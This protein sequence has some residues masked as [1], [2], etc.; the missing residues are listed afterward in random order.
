M[1]NKFQQGF[2]KRAQAYGICKFDAE[3]LL[4]EAGLGDWL[5][6]IGTNIKDWNNTS[7]PWTQLARS[8]PVDMALSAGQWMAHPLSSNPA[9]LYDAN[10]QQSNANYAG[11]YM[12]KMQHR[13]D[14]GDSP[15]A[16][17][18]RNSAIQ[19]AHQLNP[20][21]QGQVG[22]RIVGMQGQLQQNFETHQQN[23]FDAA[24]SNRN[25]SNLGAKPLLNQTA[26][27]TSMTPGVGFQPQKISP[28]RPTMN[29]FGVKTQ[30]ILD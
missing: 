22:N 9:D 30:G 6:D 28:P 1:Y 2:L 19:S 24:Q 5:G 16:Y 3:C 25:L 12:D 13:I 7:A 18:A 14:Q 15:T 21:L 4:K 29:Q 20:A 17:D 23:Q 10:R 11:A 27:P 26:P 8:K